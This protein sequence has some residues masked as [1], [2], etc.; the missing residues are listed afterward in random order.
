MKKS[1][2][3][4]GMHV[5]TN[6]NVEYIIIS[7]VEA[8]MQKGDTRANTIMVQINGHGW[9]PLDKYDDNL[10]FQPKDGREYEN[11]RCYDIKAVYTPLFYG[12]MLKSVDDYTDRFTK[13]WERSRKKMTQIDIERELGY[14]IEI[15]DDERLRGE[16]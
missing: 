8:D 2:I 15:I 1:D 3:K 14:E 7:E 11:H 16:L 9:M 6:D 10:Y 12:W 13:V 5:I 4:N